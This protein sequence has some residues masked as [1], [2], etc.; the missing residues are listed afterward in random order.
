MPLAVIAV[1]VENRDVV[2]FGVLPV[3]VDLFFR[4]LD[5]G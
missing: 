3:A 5:V 2:L 4:V 1:F